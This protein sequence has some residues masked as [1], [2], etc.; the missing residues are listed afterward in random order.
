MAINQE[1]FQLDPYYSRIGSFRCSLSG[2]NADKASSAQTKANGKQPIATQ[3]VKAI[4]LWCRGARSSAPE[5]AWA[6]LIKRRALRYEAYQENH[7]AG[8]H[9]EHQQQWNCVLVD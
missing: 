6:Q 1:S 2:R 7:H 5:F 4:S 8:Q 3:P 9:R